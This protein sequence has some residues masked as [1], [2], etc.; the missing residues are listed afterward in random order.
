MV[1][2]ESTMMWF[3]MPDA[4]TLVQWPV[5]TTL[6]VI[7]LTLTLPPL[8]AMVRVSLIPETVMFSPAGAFVTEVGGAGIPTADVLGVVTEALGLCEEM[9]GAGRSVVKPPRETWC[10]LNMK[11]TI[12]RAITP[13]TNNASRIQRPR[14]CRR[15]P[16][17]GP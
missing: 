17:G 3:W 13:N 7:P 14:P 8:Q 2:A 1:S 10:A 16:A 15:V 4:V 6:L 9:L 11:I 12:G 5:I